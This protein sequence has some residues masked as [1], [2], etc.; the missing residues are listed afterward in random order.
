M[1]I[2][3]AL[4]AALLLTLAATPSDPPNGPH[5]LQL[6]WAWMHKPTFYPLVALLIAGPPLTWLACR[7]PG[8]H[9]TALLAA[10]IVFGIIL[11][12]A[13]GD[14]TLVM[15]RILWWRVNP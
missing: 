7:T 5:F 4:Q 2:V 15:L 10:W 11:I 6:I 13:F 14:R 3:I 12:T 8:R 1:W 9:R